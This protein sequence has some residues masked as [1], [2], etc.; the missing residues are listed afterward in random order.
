MYLY[1]LILKIAAWF[2]PKARKLVEGERRSLDTL[3][4][5]LREGEQYIWFHAASVGEFEQGR[6]IIERL[7]MQQPDKKILLTFFSPS[8]YEMRKDYKFADIVV[9]LPFATKRNA[10]LFLD[11][12]K[13]EQA[14]FIKYEFWP[15]YLHEL[16]HRNIPTY[17][18]A[19]I[20]RPKQLFFRPWGGWYRSMLPCFTRLFVQDEAS[21]ALLHGIGIDNVEIAGD[22]R[23]DRVHAIAAQAKAIPEIDRF[24]EGTKQIIVAGSTWLPDEQL[25]A[26]YMQEREDVRLV[27]VPHEINQK[28]LHAIFQLFEGRFVRL[29]EA[30]ER[31]AQSC[32]ILLVDKMGLLSSIYRYATI[33]YI[34]GGFGAGIHNTVEAAVYGVPVVFG[35]NYRHFREAKGL[36]AAGCGHSIKNYDNLQMTFDNALLH[37]AEQG[38]CALRYVQS[39]LGSTDKI[40]SCLFE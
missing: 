26:R 1:I 2:N 38:E 22:P 32:R 9:Y 16:K 30:T 18:I 34:G 20:F 11:L 25:L 6:P 7:K 24:V 17:I 19:A 21:R 29:S 15:A 36:I 28:H 8:G 33:A 23:F 40:Y 4:E 13:P 35:P 10:R 14:V 12:V 39:E 5:K 27:L 31:N 3:R 37:H